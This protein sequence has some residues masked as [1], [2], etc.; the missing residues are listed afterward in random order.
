M[1]TDREREDLEVI[2]R[3]LREQNYL[4]RRQCEDWASAIE[5]LMREN[6]AL[7]ERLRLWEPPTTFSSGSQP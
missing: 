7:R 5:S 4:P 1:I 2:I 3:W 6:E